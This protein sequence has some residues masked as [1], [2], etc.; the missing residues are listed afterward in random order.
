MVKRSRFLQSR[1][2][3]NRP[4]PD[5]RH[6]R[7]WS[8]KAWR[9]VRLVLF[10]LLGLVGILFLG[11]LILRN[12]TVTRAPAQVIS[13]HFWMITALRWAVYA[14][15]IACWPQVTAGLTRLAVTSKDTEDKRVHVQ[16]SIEGW[17][18]PTA[19]ILVFY[20][21]MFPLNLAGWL[22]RLL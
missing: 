17:R 3:P 19:R 12:P 16:S 15:V 4:A 8:A 7:S 22:G 10:I 9:V 13:D 20:E 11:A 5:G 1:E 2:T 21:V 6:A 14:A 18:W